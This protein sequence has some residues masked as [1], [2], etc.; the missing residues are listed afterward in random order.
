MKDGFYVF[1]FPHFN[2]D[3]RSAVL[4]VLEALAWDSDE[5][6]IAVI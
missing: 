4:N 3:P 1:I 5:M 6:C 2:Q